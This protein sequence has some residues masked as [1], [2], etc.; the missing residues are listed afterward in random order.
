MVISLLIG[1]LFLVLV[2]LSG[3]IRLLL[4]MLTFGL[5]GTR[6]PFLYFILGFSFGNGMYAVLGI[7]YWPGYIFNTILMVFLLLK[8][9][10]PDD[11]IGEHSTVSQCGSGFLIGSILGL[12]VYLLRIFF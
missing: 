12:L 7:D 5:I 4:L 8:T 6:I 9:S 3:W 2:L 10:K 1:F 11:S